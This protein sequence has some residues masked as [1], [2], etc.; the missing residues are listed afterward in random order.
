MSNLLSVRKPHRYMDFLKERQKAAGGS[1]CSTLSSLR[2]AIKKNLPL[3]NY[4]QI[5][6][7]LTHKI[8]IQCI[9]VYSCA[10]TKC[11][12]EYF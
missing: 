9:K 7:E 4:G 8:Q 5:Y 3:H 6:V 2:N 12:H 1:G 11:E 10:M